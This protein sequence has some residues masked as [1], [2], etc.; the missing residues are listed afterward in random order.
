MISLG[1]AA[2]A[3]SGMDPFVPFPYTVGGREGQYHFEGAERQGGDHRPLW[4]VQI[5]DV[6]R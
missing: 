2:V 3:A 6:F 5:V 4:I 1:S